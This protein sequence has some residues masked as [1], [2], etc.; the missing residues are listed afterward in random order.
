[1]ATHSEPSLLIEYLY[2]ARRDNDRLTVSNLQSRRNYISSEYLIQFASN[3]RTCN[4]VGLLRESAAVITIDS[5]LTRIV[6][7]ERHVRSLD[8]STIFVPFLLFYIPF[9]WHR[10][11]YYVTFLALA[12]VSYSRTKDAKRH[13]AN[14]IRD[15]SKHCL[16]VYVVSSG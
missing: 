12:V 8:N 15:K 6:H 2:I 13:L 10:V 9:I 11:P 1:L 7:D 14:N 4:V 3:Y 5:P 16:V